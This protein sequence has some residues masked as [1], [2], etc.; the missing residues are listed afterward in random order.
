MYYK[1]EYGPS[2]NPLFF[3]NGNLNITLKRF[4]SDL[5]KQKLWKIYKI[6]RGSFYIFTTNLTIFERTKQRFTEY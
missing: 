6:L 3:L 2:Y 5:I 1:Q 4:I